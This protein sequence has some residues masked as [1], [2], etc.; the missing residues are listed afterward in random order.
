M[1][2]FFR[3]LFIT[4]LFFVGIVMAG[5]TWYIGSKVASVEDIY[6]D[7]MKLDMTSFIYSQT[8]KREKKLNTTGYMI[9]KT[10]YG[11]ILKVSPKI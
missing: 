1:N 2:K 7:T 9:M 5:A 11:Q 4:F 3:T 10:E 6:L 8:P